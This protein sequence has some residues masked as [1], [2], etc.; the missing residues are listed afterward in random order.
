LG[1]DAYCFHS[2]GSA[3]AEA[4]VRDRLWRLLHGEAGYVIGGLRQMQTKHKLSRSKRQQLAKVI[5]YLT[6]NRSS[7][8]ASPIQKKG[9]IQLTQAKNSISSA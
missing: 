9:G 2:E 8:G 4:F 6:N 7:V 5:T 1:P 3:Q